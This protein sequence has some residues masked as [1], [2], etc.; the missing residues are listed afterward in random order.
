MSASAQANS[1]HKSFALEPA[2]HPISSGSK[3]SRAAT[4]DNESSF[5]TVVALG[6]G[7]VLTIAWAGTLLWIAGYVVGIW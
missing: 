1:V 4:T 7:G 2:N 5:V 3:V 6:L